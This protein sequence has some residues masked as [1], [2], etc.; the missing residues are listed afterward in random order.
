MLA[1]TS[2]IL[3][4][5]VSLLF[6]GQA[7]PMAMPVEMKQGGA[8]AAMQCARGCCANAVCCAVVEQEQA[9][10]T[11]APPQQDQDVQLAPLE[12]RF[13]SFLFTPPAPR[14]PVVIRDD[15]NAAHTLPPLAASCIRLI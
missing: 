3:A 4:L 1:R 5:I 8:C 6:I 13:D 9:P 2:L 12:A 7:R 15:R 10:P 11:P 14:R